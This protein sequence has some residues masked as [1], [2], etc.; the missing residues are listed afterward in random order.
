MGSF[1]SQLLA[2]AVGNANETPKVHIAAVGV[3]GAGRRT[4]V[5]ATA[6][7][8]YATRTSRDGTVVVDEAWSDAGG[9]R[10]SSWSVGAARASSENKV[11]RAKSAVSS[12]SSSLSSSLPPPQQPPPQ[13][14]PPPATTSEWAALQEVI[15]EHGDVTCVV[16]IVDATDPASWPVLRQQLRLLHAGAPFLAARAPLLVVANKGDAAKAAVPLDSIV[17]ALGAEAWSRARR[18]PQRY[19]VLC[20]ALTGQGVRD[21]LGMACALS[22]RGHTGGGAKGGGGGGAGGAGKSGR[23]RSRA[24][25]GSDGDS[26]T[27]TDGGADSVDAAGGRGS[28]GGGGSGATGGSELRRRPRKARDPAAAAG[29]GTASHTNDAK[30]ETPKTKEKTKQQKQQQQQTQIADGDAEEEGDDDDKNDP[31]AEW[32]RNAAAQQEARQRGGTALQQATRSQFWTA[33]LC[34]FA[35]LFVHGLLKKHVYGSSSIE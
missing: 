9:V 7:G 35:A 11:L 26:D 24:D 30:P 32:L 29:D 20:S 31:Y 23:G 18:G 10:M 1:V 4:F 19:S 15:R 33:M 14:P 28:G 5:K 22:L 27:D 13:Q 3:R 34:L 16:A 21:A 12:L 17:A 2:G 25:D 6:L 8:N